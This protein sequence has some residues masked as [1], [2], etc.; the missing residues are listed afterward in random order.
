LR[1]ID[2]KIKNGKGKHSIIYLVDLAGSE[3][4]G[5]S[6]ARKDRLRESCSINKS[7]STLGMVI[8]ALADREMGKKVLRIPYRD[9]V[10]TRILQNALGGNSRTLMLC[11]ISPALDN[12]DETL[13]TL[14][15]ADQAKKIKCHAKVNESATDKLIRELKEE[16]ERLKKQLEF[17]GEGPSGDIDES[18][19]KAFFWEFFV[20]GN[21]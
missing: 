17:M 5:K 20:F 3:K 2:T 8:S 14:R 6:G 10:L 13:S 11:A 19:Y 4:V 15:Y 1:Q 16:N 7:L 21:C 18:K 12:Y 9:G